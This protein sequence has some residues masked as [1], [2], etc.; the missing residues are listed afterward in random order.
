MAVG[1]VVE[2]AGDVEGL[3]P[4]QARDGTT[5]TEAHFAAFSLR[6]TALEVI[7]GE[8]QVGPYAVGIQRVTFPYAQLRPL[9]ATPGPLDGR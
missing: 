8:Y 7:F 5:P 2:A 1:R 4:D 9:L 3:Q 6:P